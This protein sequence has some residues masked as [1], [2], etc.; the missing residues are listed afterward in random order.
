VYTEN[1]QDFAVN[2]EMNLD[3]V[4]EILVDPGG[5]SSGDI[6]GYCY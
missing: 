5:F 1:L 2:V 4:V 3:S 6:G